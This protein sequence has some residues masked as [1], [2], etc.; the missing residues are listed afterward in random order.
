MPDHDLISPAAYSRCIGLVYDCATD[1]SRWPEA[2]EH[3]SSLV[4]GVCGVIVLAEPHAGVTRFHRSWNLDEDSAAIFYMNYAAANPLTPLFNRFSI[5]EPYNIPSVLP[6]EQWEASALYRDF[7]RPRGFHDCVGVTIL[8][9]PMRFASVW[10]ATPP[11]TGYTGSRELQ[12]MGLIAPHVRR[13]L[14]ISDLLDA[15]TLTIN[16]LEASLNALT[17]AV[18]LLDRQGR[19]IFANES[20]S[21]R[22]E[23]RTSL[24]RTGNRVELADDIADSA[25]RSMIENTAGLIEPRTLAVRGADTGVSFVHVL[26]LEHQSIRARIAQSAAFALFVTSTPGAF[27][28]SRDA[29]SGAFGLTTAEIRVLEKLVAGADVDR[30]TRD[31]GIAMPTVRSHLSRIFD[32][33]GTSRQTDLVRLALS[34][35][36]PLTSPE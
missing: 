14:A 25:L 9:T 24:A 22:G 7:G 29:W 13:S 11:N 20:A 28:L 17:P 31:L 18:V 5:D 4:R 35:Q 8:R 6:P 34:L 1:I 32:K 12:I 33:T 26:P 19:L 36:P 3:V 2:L 10:I 23:F 30:I 15:Q 21:E 16:N 27:V